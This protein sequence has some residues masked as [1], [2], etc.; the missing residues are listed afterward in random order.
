MFKDI[1][2]ILFLFNFGVIIL[3]Y[4]FFI[5]DLLEMFCNEYDFIFS[6]GDD[7]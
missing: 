6:D 2:G 7:R 5:F 3:Y 1:Y 4:K